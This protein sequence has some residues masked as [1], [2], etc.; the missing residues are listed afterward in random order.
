MS[1]K[2]NT[3]RYYLHHVLKHKHGA[4]VKARKRFVC[5]AWQD[6]NQPKVQELLNKYKY[7]IQTEIR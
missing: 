5:V 3:R 1:S 2:D 7:T 6:A 4:V